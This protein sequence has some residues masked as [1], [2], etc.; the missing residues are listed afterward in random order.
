MIGLLGAN[1]AGKST[2]LRIIAGALE[3]SQGCV[4]ICG[5]DTVTERCAAQAQVGYLPETAPSY[6]ELRVS[7]Y[8]TYRAALK[9]LARGLR[10]AAVERVLAVA[11]LEEVA[12]IRIE[13]LSRGFCQRVGMADVLLCEPSVLLLDEPT[14]G[15]D[16][17]QSRELRELLRELGRTHT[18]VFSSHVLPEIQAVCGQ[19]L[20]LE[21]GKLVLAGALR[22]LQESAATSGSSEACASTCSVLLRLRDPERRAATLLAALDGVSGIAL[23]EDT[24][25]ELQLR[26]QLARSRSVDQQLEQ[27]SLK[28]IGAGIGLREVRR[29]TLELDDLFSRLSPPQE[30]PK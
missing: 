21:R 24:G 16:P 5:R 7:E 22:E 20:L 9:G 23:V 13:Q 28:L 11:H 17:N 14:A 10:S 18:V 3:P 1:G 8:L 19:V 2:L 26:L 4:R 25:E 27:L 6:R 12:A 15:L 29:E 30:A